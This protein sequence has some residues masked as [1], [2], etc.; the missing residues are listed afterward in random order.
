MDG[1][2]KQNL[3]D[4]LSPIIQD[5]GVMQ[6]LHNENSPEIVG[7]KTPFFKLAWKEGINITTIDTNCLDEN[8]CEN[9]VG[10]ENIG[11][12]KIIVRKIF[13][14]QLWCYALDYYYELSTIII[15]GMVINKGR[16]GY[17]IIFGNTPD[18]IKYVEFKLY[19]YCW[20]WYST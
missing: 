1:N 18:I 14:L 5:T 8:Y 12:R 4:I 10:K 15:T 20:Y 11:A 7:R 16:T 17:D 13:P 9:L 2:Y 3:G 6:K 19:D